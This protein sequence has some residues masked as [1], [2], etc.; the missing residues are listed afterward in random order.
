MEHEVGMNYYKPFSTFLLREK[1]RKKSS[2]FFNDPILSENRFVR[3]RFCLCISRRDLFISESSNAAAFPA[4][5]RREEDGTEASCSCMGWS[6][7]DDS[8]ASV[9]SSATIFPPSCFLYPGWYRF[10]GITAINYE[11]G[12]P[13]GN[14]VGEGRGRERR[15]G[16][17]QRKEE[18]G[19]R[20][21][22]DGCSSLCTQF[23]RGR[24]PPRRYLCAK[25]KCRC[26]LARSRSRSRARGKEKRKER[27]GKERR[28]GREGMVVR[29]LLT[30]LRDSRRD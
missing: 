18:R 22:N 23:P 28:G 19:S 10:H 5:A 25:I 16:R 2:A 13:K 15:R 7:R 1:K 6:N 29:P 24:R 12:R 14:V 30:F 21:K 3:A 11:G 9:R 26:R 17:G 27:A 4:L 20:K 8:I